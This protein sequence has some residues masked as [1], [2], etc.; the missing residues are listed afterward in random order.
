MILD[1]SILILQFTWLQLAIAWG[2]IQLIP[3]PVA[4]IMYI[5][6]FSACVGIL[7]SHV[8]GIVKS[9]GKR[10][11]HKKYK[12]KYS[13]FAGSGA[14]QANCIY[15]YA[16]NQ[17]RQTTWI[18]GIS[19]ILYRLG[20]YGHE[21]QIVN[22]LL[23]AFYVPLAILSFFEIFVR[24]VAGTLYFF[25]AKIVHKFLLIIAL[26]FFFTVTLLAGIVDMF[27]RR[28]QF[29]PHCYI[30]YKLP[31]FVCPSCNNKHRNL[32]PGVCGMLF[33]RCACNKAFLPTMVLTGRSYLD[34][35]C[36]NDHC[37]NELAAA[38]AKQYFLQLFGGVGAG[39]T[40]YLATVLHELDIHVLYNHSGMYTT[41]K[42]KNSMIELAEVRMTGI[43]PIGTVTGEQGGVSVLNFLIGK[44]RNDRKDV[45]APVHNLA[46]YDIFGETAISGDFINNPSHF[47]F[48][49]GF[50]LFLDPTNI[51]ILRERMNG[52]NVAFSDA[53]NDYDFGTVL[54][55]L[56]LKLFEVVGSVRDMLAVPVAVIISKA[57]NEVVQS[58]ICDFP[59]DI[60]GRNAAFK[61]YLTELGLGNAVDR[62]DDSF[63]NVAYFPVSSLQTNDPAKTATVLAPIKWIMQTSNNE[64]VKLL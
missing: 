1:R 42:P 43:L 18:C 30:S 32:T 60:E 52:S 57:D 56:T 8:L 17:I 16:N 62:L 50:L 2:F 38:N 19:G 24:V 7:I 12:L 33:A 34:C 47:G 14:Y 3:R 23:A 25:L 53:V 21:S 46:M 37:Q 10:L 29:C 15:K 39:K 54:N 27:M 11:Q 51:P 63:T 6:V 58:D 4:W 35:I 44:C 36:P 13:F 41:G 45:R 28:Q 22:F 9:C 48:C 59:Q 26:S 20:K 55:Q 40:S 49:N 5:V 31:I 64:L 61:K